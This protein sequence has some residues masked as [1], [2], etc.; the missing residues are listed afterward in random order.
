MARGVDAAPEP[1]LDTDGAPI[2]STIA[3]GEIERF[4]VTLGAGTF[5]RLTVEQR[6]VDLVVRLRDPDG[7]PRLEVDSP[8][9]FRGPER[10]VAVVEQAGVYRVEIEAF[11]GQPGGGYGLTATTASP[12]TAEH[13][14]HAEA[15]AE[16]ARAETLRR[17]RRYAEAEALYRR[18]GRHWSA[19]GDASGGAEVEHRLGRIFADQ[20]RWPEAVIAQERAARAFRDLGRHDREAWARY[21]LGRAH[22]FTGDV[23]SARR[24]YQEALRL[25]RGE[26]DPLG[27]A[28]TASNLGLAS[29]LVGE[30][31]EAIDHYRQALDLY[32]GPLA[33]YGRF[34]FDDHATTVFNLG[35]LLAARGRPRRALDA[36]ERARA[37]Y[38]ESGAWPRLAMVE[39]AIAAVHGEAGEPGRAF[40]VLQRSLTLSLGAGADEHA[41]VAMSQ[42][43]D[44]YRD[45]GR[46]DLA[47]RLLDRALDTFR[48]SGNRRSEARTWLKIGTL[49]LA[50]GR[51]ADALDA[52]GAALV[53][54]REL[55]EVGAVASVLTEM[56]RAYRVDGQLARASEAV[57]EA[58]GI[59][60]SLRLT[61]LEPSL[62][63][64]QFAT[65]QDAYDVAI[66]I[67]FDLH[68]ESPLAGHHREAFAIGERARAR[69]LLDGL[70]DAR[71]M[72][73]SAPGSHAGDD[74]EVVRWRQRLNT[75]ARRRARAVRDGSGASVVD[76]IER[77]IRESVS[78]L[79][80][81]RAGSRTVSTDDAG[82]LEAAVSS[83]AVVD[84][85]ANRGLLVYRI[86]RE[87]AYR[88]HRASDGDLIMTRLA[89]ASAIESAA[90]RSHRLLGKSARPETAAA[91]RLAL[92]RLADL[93]LPTDLASSPRRLTIIPDGVLHY[94]PFAALP[95]PGA[96]RCA[97]D[98][99]LDHH[100]IA[101]LPS[102]AARDALRHRRKD[103]RHGF[104][105]SETEMSKAVAVIADPAFADDQALA[106]WRPLRHT[107]E[108]AAAILNQ[109]PAG[110]GFA[111]TGAD[112][113]KRLVLEGGLAGYRV[114]HFATHG[115]L[116]A[117][118]PALSGV[119]LSTVDARG[120]AIDGVLRAH[121]IAELSLDA[122][123]VVLSA[124]RTALGEAVR[125]EGLV[126]LT[127]AFLHAG[128]SEV[129]VSLWPVDDRATS[130]LMTR[131]YRHLFRDR[132]PAS[133]ALVRAQR[134]M[135]ESSAWKAPY[136][137]AGFVIRGHAESGERPT[138]NHSGDAGFEANEPSTEARSRHREAQPYR[139]R[140]RG[141][142]HGHSSS[143]RRGHGAD[144]SGR[145]A[146]D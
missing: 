41:A 17:R 79:E 104:T 19:L 71:G 3:G 72:P 68:A 12:A 54:D 145:R 88:W 35:T 49:A 122:D 81:L 99:L 107:R 66:D 100:E 46:F 28:Y 116:D 58:I 11:A 77:S 128:A 27:A 62:R 37:F 142:G 15:A 2:E 5:L 69:L 89:P 40:E 102:L 9:G 52:L 36:F 25:H 143:G 4:T 55:G 115:V 135:A 6:D 114:L 105:G 61:T 129:V 91:T 60:E 127:Q 132:L 70:R 112:A 144:P 45:R 124:C 10:L 31:Q 121:E 87:H 38:R 113:N 109:A 98:R 94:V 64:A 47:G 48:A 56:A 44:L 74:D 80:R 120:R 131:F 137:W 117:R 24:S 78:A 7:D 139:T 23:D 22:Y 32:A 138:V 96:G 106:P 130:V 53:I 39:N 101:Y 141:S 92:C 76:T 136:F 1:I 110:S 13:R 8:T 34:V 119:V 90:L 108:E 82:F 95:R 67:R 93:I 50:G 57:D 118:N 86:G 75:L 16:F 14:A 63:A 133:A 125:G 84:R 33:R 30:T 146:R 83:G 20:R 134:F 29:E 126:G 140:A 111:A 26:G 97:D 85:M 123:L 73:R 43:A 21:N 42:L 103:R 18:A 51:E 59:F 65:A